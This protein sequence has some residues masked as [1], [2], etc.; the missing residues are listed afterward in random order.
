MRRPSPE[1][2]SR[3]SRQPPT[4]YHPHPSHKAQYY[5]LLVPWEAVDSGAC[6]CQCQWQPQADSEC[7]CQWTRKAAM[8]LGLEPPVSKPPQIM[9]DA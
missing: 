2:N 7:Q 4:R 3:A 9:M 6:L 8:A 5:L 1:R